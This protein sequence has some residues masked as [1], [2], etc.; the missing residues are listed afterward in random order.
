[1]YSIEKVNFN[2]SVEIK[3]LL[4]NS[5]SIAVDKG[6]LLK[7]ILMHIDNKEGCV[8]KKI[9]DGDSILGVWLSKE[10]ERH[11]SLSYFY[12][13]EE[14]RRKSI[15]IEFFMSCMVLISKDKSLVICAKDTTGFS[16]YVEPIEGQKDTYVFKGFR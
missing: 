15:V 16:R 14:I 13:A 9:V 3:K 11:T 1:M 4:M 5:K 7:E 6:K 12:V 2:D 10:F 8:A